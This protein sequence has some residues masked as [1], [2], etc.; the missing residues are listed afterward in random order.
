MGN[1]YQ[2]DAPL[3]TSAAHKGQWS[4]N[5]DMQMPRARPHARLGH[6]CASGGRVLN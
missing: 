2:T 1:S 3:I 5:E 6:K 4:R